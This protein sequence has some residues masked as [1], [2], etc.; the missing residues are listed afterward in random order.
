MLRKLLLSIVAV[1]GMMAVSQTASAQQ[2]LYVCKT[3]TG[4]L[5]VVAPTAKCPGNMS[6]IML[7]V[8][9]PPGPRGPQGVAGPQGPKDR[10]EHQDQLDRLDRPDRPDQLDRPDRPDQTAHR[11]LQVRPVQ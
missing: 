6:P 11:D 8:P 1:I 10:P 5:F 9:G 4:T 7:D 3:T 2:V